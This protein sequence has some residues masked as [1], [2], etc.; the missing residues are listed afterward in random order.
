MLAARLAANRL[1]GSLRVVAGGLTV[2]LGL[3]ARLVLGEGHHRSP[4]L[5]P[6]PAVLPRALEAAFTLATLLLLLLAL[7]AAWATWDPLVVDAFDYS[8]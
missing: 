6:I 3:G 5:H 1:P 8:V 2:Y 7:G 4:G